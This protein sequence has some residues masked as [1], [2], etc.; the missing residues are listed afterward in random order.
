MDKLLSLLQ[1]CD[2]ALPIGGFSHSAGLETY[3]QYGIVKHKSS[4]KLFIEQQLS[5]NVFYTDAALVSL[6]YDAGERG[7]L[8]ELMQLNDECS[9]V[10]FPREMRQASQKMGVRLSKLF[11]SLCRNDFVDQFLFAVN[12]KNSIIHHPVAFGL[13]ASTLGIPKLEM[14]SGFYYT[15]AAGMVTNSVKLVPLGQ[16]E[17]QEILYSLHNLIEDLAKKSMNPDRELI[18]VCCAG[19]DIRAMQHERLYSRLYMS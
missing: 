18:G 6:A 3:V 11:S 13:F 15:T 14:I 17:G 9:A 19:F 5:Q 1:L 8:N 2:P 10:K 7:N 12:T 4:T 16:N